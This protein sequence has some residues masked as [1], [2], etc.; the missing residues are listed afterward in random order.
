M[1]RYDRDANAR[2][3]YTN[4]AEH[5]LETKARYFRLATLQAYRLMKER[6]PIADVRKDISQFNSDFSEYLQARIAYA[7]AI[8]N[9]RT[10]PKNRAPLPG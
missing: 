9:L 6:P 10:Q 8:D 1:R 5:R 2:N 7:Y 3:N 4:A